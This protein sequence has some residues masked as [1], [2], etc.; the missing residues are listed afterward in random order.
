MFDSSGGPTRVVDAHTGKF[1]LDFSEL[2]WRLRVPFTVRSV[3]FDPRMNQCLA[4]AA[5]SQS[6]KDNRAVVLRKVRPEQW[7]GVAW[8][9][10][11]WITVICAG[12]LLWS[13]Y[14][15]RITIRS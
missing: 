8:L 12:G 2:R 4:S 10:E 11:F 13:V 7:Y 14:R 15:R 1:V 9:P 3:S 5:T 6:G